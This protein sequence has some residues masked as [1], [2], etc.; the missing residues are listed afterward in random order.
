MDIEKTLVDSDHPLLQGITSL[1]LAPGNGVPFVIEDG[2]VLAHARNWPVVALIDY[3]ATGGQVVALAD[4]GLLGSDGGPPNLQ[5][6]LNLCCLR[7]SMIPTSHIVSVLRTPPKAMVAAMKHVKPN[8]SKN[9]PGCRTKYKKSC[10]T[11]IQVVEM[12]NLPRSIAW[13]GLIFL[14]AACGVITARPTQDKTPLPSPL[15]KTPTSEIEMARA[16]RRSFRCALSRRLP[17]GG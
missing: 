14:L 4:L 2:L 10:A 8:S 6:W 9:G 16:A 1:V 17:C 11:R 12:T 5:F 15:S 7:E 13:I 3:G